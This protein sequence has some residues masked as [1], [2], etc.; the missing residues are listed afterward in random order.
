MEEATD[1]RTVARTLDAEA[2]HGHLEWIAG[3]NRAALIAARREGRSLVLAYR[4]EHAAI[5]RELVRRERR[6]CAFLSFD[7]KEAAAAVALVI[8]VPER[9][10]DDIETILEP[11]KATAA[12]EAGCGCS[13]ALRENGGDDVCA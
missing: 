9:V 12:A 11:F 6:C 4:P 3:L 8:G 10:S 5:V 13:S 1:D 2:W 7:F